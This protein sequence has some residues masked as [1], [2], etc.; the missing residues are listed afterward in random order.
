MTGMRSETA[1]DGFR[2]AYDRTGA[3][4]FSP[5]EAPARFAVAVAVTR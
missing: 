3:G 1:V 2:L 4:H 5:L